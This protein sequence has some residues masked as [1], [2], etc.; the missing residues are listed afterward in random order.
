[1]PT[2]S[3][4]GLDFQRV[5]YRERVGPGAAPSLN[6]FAPVYLPVTMPTAFSDDFIRQ[7]QLG[8]YAQEQ[9]AYGKWRFLAGVREDWA[10]R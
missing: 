6:V 10:S 3:L 4:F 9:I 7:K 2:R 5:L 1:M 8:V